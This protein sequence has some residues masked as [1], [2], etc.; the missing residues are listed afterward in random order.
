MDAQCPYCGGL[1]QTSF[2]L[3]KFCNGNLTY[4][5][6]EAIRQAAIVYQNL[7][8]DGS[9]EEFAAE[10]RKID[11]SRKVAIDKK[12]QEV[13]EQKKK[14]EHEKNQR[15]KEIQAQ[16]LKD[17]EIAEQKAEVKAKRISEMGSLKRF[18]YQRWYILV[19]AGLI[20][21][22]AAMQLVAP[23]IREYRSDLAIKNSYLEEINRLEIKYCESVVP[24]L[25]G[26]EIDSGLIRIETLRNEINRL[27]AS[28]SDS[29]V[30]VESEISNRH[31]EIFALGSLD[32]GKWMILDSSSEAQVKISDFIDSC[33]NITK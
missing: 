9:K 17:K 27:S 15:Q 2:S 10:V 23:A 16:I 13:E 1:V 33:K 19:L 7:I 12:L 14:L 28:A 20:L 3:C 21:F 24:I 29:G 22:L 8:E 30:S 5:T 26:N 31:E 18:A 4:G 6:F 25:N 11:D 32:T